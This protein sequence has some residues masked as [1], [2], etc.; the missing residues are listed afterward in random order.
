MR[1]YG[2]KPNFNRENK[3]SWEVAQDQ[4]PEETI[5][6]HD[7]YDN[8]QRTR[9]RI[10]GKQKPWSR[11]LGA[12]GIALAFFLA[13]WLVVSI[14]QYVGYRTVNPQIA[15]MES[16]ISDIIVAGPGALFN[17]TCSMGAEK[18]APAAPVK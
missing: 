1:R 11:M 17:G 5:Q 6:Y 3:S 4:R 16:S 2:D 7:V 12:F 18:V 10:D 13:A 9:S 14:I 8:Q 15:A